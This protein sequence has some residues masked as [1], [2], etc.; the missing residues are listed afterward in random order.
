[1]DVN[2]VPEEN[3]INGQEQSTACIIVCRLLTWTLTPWWQDGHR[4]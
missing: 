2:E 1:L 3:G 4:I